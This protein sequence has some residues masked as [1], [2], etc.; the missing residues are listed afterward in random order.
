MS[1]RTISKVDS[2][3]VKIEAILYASGRPVEIEKLKGVLKTS[4]RRKVINLVRELA[5]I[6]DA[7]GG[8]LIV[9]E[10]P[11]GMVALKVREEY[12]DVARAFA[13]KP[14]LKPGPL[15]TLSYIAY[16][17]PIELKEVIS[18]LGKRVQ[19]HLR[20][21]EEMALI[22][23]EESDKGI[24]LKTTRYFAEYFRFGAEGDTKQQLRRLFEN[25]R[26]PKL[27]NG[28]NTQPAILKEA[29]GMLSSIPEAV[30]YSAR[31]LPGG[32]EESRIS[33]DKAPS[34]TQVSPPNH[35]HRGGKISLP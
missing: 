1:K 15:K 21:L 9:E 26:I 30:A 29:Y 19:S 18:R 24:L 14:L 8:A 2:K 4:S 10:L 34:P 31:E 13:S 25:L 17:E 27:D 6:Y 7:R 16:Y 11:E 32:L 22:I 35:L 20:T 23:K 3:V 12:S 5:R 33:Q 28:D